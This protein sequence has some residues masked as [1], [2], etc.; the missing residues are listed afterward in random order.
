MSLVALPEHLARYLSAMMTRALRP[1]SAVLFFFL[2]ACAQKNP[3]SMDILSEPITPNTP[4]QEMS[5]VPGT[6]PI[7]STA[8]LSRQPAPSEL[9]LGLSHADIAHIQAEAKRHFLKHWPIVSERSRFVHERVQETIKRMGAPEELVVLPIVESGYNPYAFSHA[10]AMGLWQIMPGTARLLGLRDK[11]GVNGRRDVVRSTE[12]AIKYLLKMKA[13]FGNWPLAFAAY[14]RGPGSIR[15]SLRKHPWQPQ[16][17]LDR[18]PIPGI[19]R[20]YVRHVLG[21]AALTRLGVIEFPPAHK[22]Q[23]LIVQG[24]VDLQRLAKASGINRHDIFRFNPELDYSQYV[25]GAIT[26]H[27][28]ESIHSIA[29]QNLPDATPKQ[30]QIKV[31][32]GDNLW[33]LARKYGT[34]VSHLRRINP[35]LN[36]HLSIGKALMVPATKQLRASTSLNP[37]LTNGRRILYKVRR[38]DTLWHIAQRF[39]TST[40]AIARAN[41]LKENAYLQPGDRLWVRARIRPS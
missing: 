19:T 4:V 3:S 2:A 24:P 27:V 35:G 29:Q 11:P 8:L 23:P 5:A 20:A 39:G 9:L 21:L 30:V 38:G 18:L 17:G 32:K 26:L 36:T 12:T 37:L 14:H 40:R 34:S 28:P 1:G 22:T 7:I 13:K 6:A 33:N 41:S 31:R 25:K 16:D 15:K 10:G